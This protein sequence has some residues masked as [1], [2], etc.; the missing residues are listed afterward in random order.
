VAPRGLVGDPVV[1][2]VEMLSKG[3]GEATLS[4]TDV[5]LLALGAGHQVHQVPRRAVHPA[6]DPYR[7][8]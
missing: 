7:L 4:L 3:L 6:V 2:D 8:T 1:D 5:L